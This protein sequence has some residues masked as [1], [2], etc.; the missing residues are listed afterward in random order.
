VELSFNLTG[1]SGTF[2]QGPFR[3]LAFEDRR[4]DRSFFFFPD[5]EG[6]YFGL[7]LS[8]SIP[9][10]GPWRGDPHYASVVLQSRLG[11]VD[12]CSGDLDVVSQ[13][14]QWVDQFG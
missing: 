3:T 5:L 13:G 9:A 2:T 12:R 7:I 14:W 8:I 11:T 4:K 6:L 1:M 10:L